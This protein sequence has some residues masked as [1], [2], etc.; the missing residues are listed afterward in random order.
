MA[1]S[2]RCQKEECIFWR[3]LPKLGSSADRTWA[4]CPRATSAFQPILTSSSGG[5]GG[6]AGRHDGD[7][8]QFPDN[9]HLSQT[10]HGGHMRKPSC[11]CSHWARIF[12]FSPFSD[13]YLLSHKVGGDDDPNWNGFCDTWWLSWV[14]ERNSVEGPINPTPGQRLSTWTKVVTQFHFYLCKS[15]FLFEPSF[16]I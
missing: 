11:W 8:C 16:D 13:K 1:C 6:Q 12:S 4:N 5:N 14:S 3:L 2:D 9:K 7:S 10:T 15:E